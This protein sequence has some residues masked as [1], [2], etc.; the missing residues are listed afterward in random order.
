MKIDGVRLCVCF[1]FIWLANWTIFSRLETRDV[2]TWHNVRSDPPTLYQT[3]RQELSFHNFV[4]LHLLCL[5]AFFFILL[6]VKKTRR[7]EENR[8]EDRVTRVQQRSIRSATWKV[9]RTTQPRAPPTCPFCPRLPCWAYLCLFVCLS[10]AW[11]HTFARQIF[12]LWE[13]K[14]FFVFLFISKKIQ[15]DLSC[16]LWL[17]RV[18]LSIHFC[19]RAPLFL[20]NQKNSK[21][22]FS[23][24][25]KAAGRA[26]TP[27]KRIGSMIHSPRGVNIP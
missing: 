11:K 22:Y 5:S 17:R 3:S 9:R 13:K 26:A 18:T 4:L 25:R 7:G 2:T 1:F 20:S 21:F 14:A 19:V 12:P 15:S 27:V 23:P 8:E 6:L 10:N 16:F 24:W